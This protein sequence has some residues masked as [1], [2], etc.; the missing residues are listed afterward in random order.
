MNIISKIEGRIFNLNFNQLQIFLLITKKQILI[1]FYII[2][3]IEVTTRS[4]QECLFTVR[5]YVTP[6][7]ILYPYIITYY[8]ALAEKAING[9]KIVAPK[10]L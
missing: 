10:T 2:W 7:D 9:D 5:I 8:I 3:V 1:D 6:L 4:I